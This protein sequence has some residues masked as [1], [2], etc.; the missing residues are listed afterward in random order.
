MQTVYANR[1][2]FAHVLR[3]AILVSALVISTGYPA[4][5]SLGDC[6]QPVSDGAS[7]VASDCLGVLQTSTGG[8]VCTHDCLCDVDG[9]GS[10]V[11]TDALICLQ[12]AVGLGVDLICSSCGVPVLEGFET[13]K[14]LILPIEVQTAY[15][16][17]TIFFHVSWE[18]DR[19]DSHDYVQYTGG[20]WQREGFPRRE[21]QS[22]I[23]DDPARGPT[24]R[25]SN[26]YES[27][28]TFFVDDPTGPNAV[29]GF[30][31]YGCFLT[32]H[33]DSRAMPLWDPS[34]NL[35][36]YLIDG[37]TG[38]LDLWH[39]RLHRA[40]PIGTS[41]DQFV[42]VIPMGG[43]AGG[44]I[45][46]EGT[47]PW[48]TNDIGEDGN[49]TFAID[50]STSNGRF[51]FKFD[52]V[53]TDPLRYF[54]RDD[55]QELGAASLATG[56]DFADALVMGYVP[57]EGDTIPRRRL[58]TPTGSA[59]DISGLGTTFTPSDDDP[60]VGRW[61]LNTQRLLDTGNPDDTALG[62]GG[63]Y[64]IAFAVHTGRVTV[65]D[66]YVGFAVTLSL[67]GASADI[68]A[69]KIAGTGRETLPDFSDSETFPTSDI[70]LF[71]PGITSLAFLN[72]DNEG[73]VYI[74]PETDSEID[75]THFGANALLTQGLGC[76]DCHTASDGDVFDPP[77]AGGFDSGSMETLVPMRGGVET[78]TPLP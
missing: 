49:P 32:C 16:D 18:G 31:E 43:T 15:N 5:A 21:N 52:G 27:R 3:L 78:P 36:K 30:T 1:A 2:C 76:R 17:D 58:R 50:P 35:T 77:Q 68:D 53:F 41:D 11:A 34:T 56:I 9:S 51:A 48:Q 72:N 62:D 57:A 45:R 4:Q 25:T 60:L 40:N 66:H 54:R 67:G 12:R 10:T 63:I 47:G 73:M 7:T 65:R 23:D 69:V 38:T 75:Q 70:N 29:P 8:D 39:R 46:D 6:G 22:T 13:D 20:Q 44:R 71:L 74:D 14:P 26:I 33:D 64:N 28:L 24:N 19:G 42:S 55:A 59:G 37:T 61:N